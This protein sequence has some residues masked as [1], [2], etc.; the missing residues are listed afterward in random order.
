MK[1]R[2]W[3][4]PTIL[5]LFMIRIY[6]KTISFDHGWFKRFYP[7]GFCRFYPTCS[8]Y[9]YT[10]IERHGIFKGGWYTVIRILKCNPFHPGGID[11]PPK[12]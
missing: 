5:V 3:F 7:N 4:I 12:K 6:Q 8:E 1:W 10:C 2:Y 11:E 9:G